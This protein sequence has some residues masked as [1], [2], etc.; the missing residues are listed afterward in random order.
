VDAFHPSAGLGADPELI[1][2]LN[3]SP[4]EF[5]ARIGPTTAGW[6]RRTRFRR[7]VA[8]ALGNIGD[9]VAVPGLV[10]ALSDPE[11]VIRAHAAWS[12]G[13]IGTPQARLGLEKALGR[14]TDRRI[15]D[16]TQ[17]DLRSDSDGKQR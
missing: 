16:E 6:I 9:P 12:L 14:E 3:I 5:K 4:Q 11:P 17:A 8:V 1:P 10:E 15:K 7:N 13:R 2:L